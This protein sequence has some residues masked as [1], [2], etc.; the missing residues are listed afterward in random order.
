ELGLSRL[1]IWRPGYIHVE[2]GREKKSASDRVGGLLY[3]IV[4]FIPGVANSTVE[5]AHAM[6]EAAF[7]ETGEARALYE[8]RDIARL[9][10]RYRAA[11]PEAPAYPRSRRRWLRRLG[12]AGVVVLLALGL[13]VA[14]AWEALGRA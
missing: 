14:S 5:I 9:A 11:H 6:L 8:A 13:A 2:A 10:R 12:Y 1:A 4:R 7:S 3:P